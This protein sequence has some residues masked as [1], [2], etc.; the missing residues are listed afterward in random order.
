ML[1]NNHLIPILIFSCFLAASTGCSKPMDSCS[2]SSPDSSIEINFQL[3]KSSSGTFIPVY[4]VKF[5]GTP[6]IDPSSLG[7]VL[8]AWIRWAGMCGTP[9]LQFNNY[10]ETAAQHTLYHF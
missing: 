10:E 7:M 9:W 5:K 2:I 8:T 3:E 1:N 4:S 6:M